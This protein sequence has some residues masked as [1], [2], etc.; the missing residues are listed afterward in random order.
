MLKRILLALTFVAVLGA[1]GLGM[2]S[3]AAAGHGCYDDYSYGG[4]GY[5]TYQPVYYSDWGY[6]TYYRSYGY[7]QRYDGHHR[8]HG[9]HGHH[10]DR[11]G[12]SFSI[13]F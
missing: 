10:H 11:G 2:S 13:G 4:Y 5:R 9:H 8:Y 6:P 3:K 12:I 7:P 1:A